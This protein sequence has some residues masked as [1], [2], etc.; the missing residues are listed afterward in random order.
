MTGNLIMIPDM[1]HLVQDLG[2]CQ[3]RALSGE[4]PA[5]L[6]AGNQEIRALL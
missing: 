1:D 5:H 3:S 4:P 6:V 2:Q